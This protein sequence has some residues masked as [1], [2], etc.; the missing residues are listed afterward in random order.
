MTR[1]KDITIAADHPAY[2]G[3]FPNFPVLPGAVLLDEVL[4]AIA[5]ERGG[6]LNVWRIASAKF[7][8]AVRPGDALRIEF[9][10]QAGGAISFSVLAA[11]RKVVSG[12]LNER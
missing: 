12:V 5:G 3:H 2:A 4:R 9:D 10:A 1:S 8:G 7:L 6:N 11:G